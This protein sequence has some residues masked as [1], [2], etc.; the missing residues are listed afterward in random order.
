MKMASYKDRFGEWLFTPPGAI[1]CGVIGIS[2]VDAVRRAWGSREFLADFILWWIAGIIYL[3]FIC[4][5]FAGGIYIGVRIAK[6]TGMKWVGWLSGI[7]ITVILIGAISA[8]A[9]AIP[10][11]GWRLDVFLSSGES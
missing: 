3:P 1:I 9:Q 4:A 10:G 5:P 2:A 6:R 8:A 7:A 11:I